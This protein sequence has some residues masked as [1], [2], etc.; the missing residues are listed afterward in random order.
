MTTVKTANNRVVIEDLQPD[1]T[2]VRVV[3]F[4]PSQDG[5]HR[6]QFHGP[7]VPVEDHQSAID[8][9]V[10]MATQMEHSL[11]VVPVTG[12]DVLR[13]ARASDVVATLDDQERGELRRA[14]A[15]AMAE[16]M[17]DSDDPVLR[18]DAYDVL[19]DMKVVLP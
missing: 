9:A 8:W 6:K 14:C 19:V 11:Y 2:H 5:L 3:W 4:G 18:N 17:R 12:L 1:D 10:S 15:A 7:M 13:S 16:V